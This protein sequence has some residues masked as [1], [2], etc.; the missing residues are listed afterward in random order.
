MGPVVA[1]WTVHLHH[2]FGVTRAWSRPAPAPTMGGSLGGTVY[3]EL[4]REL[5]TVGIDDLLGTLAERP[6]TWFLPFLQLAAGRADPVAPNPQ[7]PRAGAV[8][9][10]WYRITVP[11][12]AGISRFIWHPH[13]HPRLFTG[14]TGELQAT[15]DASACELHLR[16]ATEGGDP[17]ACA[18]ALV[19]LLELL[20]TAVEGRQSVG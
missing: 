1:G 6:A 2:R 11:D 3:R 10:H 15:G 19:T 7:P 5:A 16:G 17:G 14:F 9:N 13:G 8:R 4:R 18:T 20:A 12:G